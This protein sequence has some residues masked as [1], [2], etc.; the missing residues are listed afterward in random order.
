MVAGK[1]QGQVKPWQQNKQAQHLNSKQ[2]HDNHHFFLKYPQ[3]RVALDNGMWFI[4]VIVGFANV[5]HITLLIFINLPHKGE[6]EGVGWRLMKVMNDSRAP[7]GSIARSNNCFTSQAADARISATGTP[8]RQWT[9]GLSLR[10][11]WG[12]MPK[13]ASQCRESLD[14]SGLW[15][16]D[17][18]DFSSSQDFAS[19]WQDGNGQQHLTASNGQLPTVDRCWQALWYFSAADSCRL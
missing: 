5:C 1:S 19:G 3:E 11:T 10:A 18:L 13:W 4:V 12:T 7:S 2:L 16:S 15:A 8:W 9:W 14:V 6:G 17:F